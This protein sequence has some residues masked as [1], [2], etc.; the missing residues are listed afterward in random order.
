MT[1]WW[2]LY[3]CTSIKSL[4]KVWEFTSHSAAF[5]V[6]THH[7]YT[8]AEKQ[9]LYTITKC[10]SLWSSP[11]EISYAYVHLCSSHCI[12][13]FKANPKLISFLPYDRKKKCIWIWSVPGPDL[14]Y[15]DSHSEMRPR[16]KSHV[17][18]AYHHRFMTYWAQA[19]GGWF[20]LSKKK[21]AFLI[22][23]WGF[24]LPVSTGA[25]VLPP[26]RTKGQFLTRW[27]T[28]SHL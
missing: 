23:L 8:F 21:K 17:D 27:E 24:E 7:I 22:P 19:D 26:K 6:T 4:I 11:W 25:S 5:P 15:S 20:S 9:T 28:S 3:Y 16:L 18:Q 13:P 10:I 14:K 12:F 2:A 1:L